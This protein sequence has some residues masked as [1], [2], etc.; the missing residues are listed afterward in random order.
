[1]NRLRVAWL[2]TPGGI[3]GRI[4]MFCPYG[5]VHVLGAI[6]CTKDQWLI[7][8]AA[9][10]RAGFEFFYVEIPSHQPTPAS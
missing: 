9:L 5:R 4:E 2:E 8:S 7:L 10:E 1:M 3:Q 6:S